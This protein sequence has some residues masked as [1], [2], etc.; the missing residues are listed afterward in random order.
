LPFKE[1]SFDPLI[2]LNVVEHL[3]KERGITALEELSRVAH[4]VIVTTSVGF[5]EADADPLN[6]FQKHMSGWYSEDLKYLGYKVRGFGWFRIPSLSR[7]VPFLVLLNVVLVPLLRC[8][9]RFAYH[10][11]GVRRR[12]PCE[13]IN[14]HFPSNGSVRNPMDYTR[15]ILSK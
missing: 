7:L 5:V 13:S 11:Y 1:N 14:E 6:P 4:A 2:C 10:M 8:A 9:P 3:Q 15:D 12:N